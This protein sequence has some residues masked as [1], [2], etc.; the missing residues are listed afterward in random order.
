MTKVVVGQNL[1]IQAQILDRSKAKII[2]YK[3]MGT[4]AL[5]IHSLPTLHA[6]TKEHRRNRDRIM[7]VKI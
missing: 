7:Y 5:A 1:N 2:L 6:A 4:T 3:S